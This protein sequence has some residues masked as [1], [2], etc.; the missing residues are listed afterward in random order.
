LK[1]PRAHNARTAELARYHEELTREFLARR[2][3]CGAQATVIAVLPGE[4]DRNYCLACLVASLPADD[5]APARPV[6][7]PVRRGDRARA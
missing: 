6:D 7:K 4:P 1:A 5:A 3:A 2:C